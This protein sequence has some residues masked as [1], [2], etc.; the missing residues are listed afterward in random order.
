MKKDI[1][2]SFDKKKV[3]ITAIFSVCILFLITKSPTDWC[4]TC[5]QKK[6]IIY[7]KQQDF[8]SVKSKRLK[9]YLIKQGDYLFQ[10]T[11]YSRKELLNYYSEVHKKIGNNI[12]N[13][14]KEKYIKKST[15]NELLRLYKKNDFNQLGRVIKT[16]SFLNTNSKSEAEKNY[17][18]FLIAEIQNHKN[19]IDYLDKSIKNNSY[20]ILYLIEKSDYLERNCNKKEALNSYFDAITLLNNFDNEKFQNTDNRGKIYTKIADIYIDFRQFNKALDFYN[21]SLIIY[22]INGKEYEKSMVL[23]KIAEIMIFKGD[24]YDAITNYKYILSQVSNKSSLYLKTLLNISK[25]YYE[26]GNYVNGLKFA[27]EAEI[28]TGKTKNKLLNADAQ[29]LKC[30]NYEYLGNYELSTLNCKNSIKTL[31]NL[32]FYNA[33]NYNL[34]LNIASKISF[35]S[36]IRDTKMALNYIENALRILKE[37]SQNNRLEEVKIKEKILYAKYY[38]K[39]EKKELLKLYREIK[40]DY[41]TLNISK[42]CCLDLIIGDS[43]FFQKPNKKNPNDYLKSEKYYLEALKDYEFKNNLTTAYSRLASFYN[44]EKK[45]N[46]MKFYIEE[47]IRLEGISRKGNHHFIE[48][49]KNIQKDIK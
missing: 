26:Y 5:L 45:F 28:I 20:E 22:D 1:K 12:D 30:L 29:Y 25:A 43:F 15:R 10:N 13:L 31:K 2:L 21:K 19:S 35:A 24:Y 41:Q 7:L 40:N 4:F 49:Y 32:L 44:K 18:S 34:Y 42:N 37:Q 38:L 48:Y 39:P 3:I 6:D 8:K 46:E 14:N 9:S 47:A 17:L 33:N 11:C 16:I 36:S 27:N 23:S